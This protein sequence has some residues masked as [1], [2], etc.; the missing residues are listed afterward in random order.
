M[1]E[2]YYL[3]PFVYVMCDLRSYL[4]HSSHACCS[5]HTWAACV[6]AGEGRRHVSDV[7]PA[8]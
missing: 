1:R 6:L 3:I 7:W 5:W 2:H 4:E 8:G